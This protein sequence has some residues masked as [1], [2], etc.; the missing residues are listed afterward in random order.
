MAANAKPVLLFGSPSDISSGKVSH[1]AR[2]GLCN[3]E[4]TIRAPS[5][6]RPT[7]RPVMKGVYSSVIT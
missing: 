5:T 2:I 1:Q 3:F 7:G 6:Q 4:P